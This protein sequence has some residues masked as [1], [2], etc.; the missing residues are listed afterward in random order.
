MFNHHLPNLEIIVKPL[1]E[2]WPEKQ[3]KIFSIKQPVVQLF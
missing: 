1:K 2:V 3:M